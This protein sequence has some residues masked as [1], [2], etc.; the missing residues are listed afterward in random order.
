M[1]KQRA[2]HRF[3]T[4]SLAAAV[5]TAILL[6][7]FVAPLFAADLDSY[8]VLRFPAGYYLTAQGA[9]IVLVALMFWFVG[10]QEDADRKLGA[11]E[12]H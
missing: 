11:A 4:T 7:T 2:Q 10:R 12:D 3:R 5:L 6:L 9:I 1:D 8:S